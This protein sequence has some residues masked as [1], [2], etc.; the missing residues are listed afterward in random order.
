MGRDC[1]DHRYTLSDNLDLVLPVFWY[2][3]SCK[4]LT[5]SVGGFEETSFHSPYKSWVA[6]CHFCLCGP[7]GIEL[8]GTSKSPT[9]SVS[10]RKPRLGRCPAPGCPGVRLDARVESSLET[11]SS[12]E[13]SQPL[14]VRLR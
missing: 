9:R 10:P 5:V 4:V 14:R 3:T 13:S 12:S 1:H 8:H 2:E 6:A 7:G 11:R